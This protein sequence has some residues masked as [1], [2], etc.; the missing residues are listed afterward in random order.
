MILGRVVGQVWATRKDP[1]L[2]RAKL[3]VIRPHGWYEPA[4]DS[5]HLVAVDTLDAG[6]GD[7]V[8]V[9]LGDPARRAL[10]LDP[11]DRVGAGAGAEVEATV[12][13]AVLWIFDRTSFDDGAAVAPGPAGLGI[14][15]RL[16]L[17]G[18]R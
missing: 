8:I 6:V 2:E 1:R 17:P 4:F 9:C 5:R 10:A 14:R 16:E 7:D 11:G 18:A 3:L 12:D 13:A 15:R